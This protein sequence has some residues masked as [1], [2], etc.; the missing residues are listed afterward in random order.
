MTNNK[1]NGH[2]TQEEVSE[3]TKLIKLSIKNQQEINERLEELESKRNA[4]GEAQLRLT[5]LTFDTPDQKILEFTDIPPGAPRKIANEVTLEMLFHPDVQSGKVPLTAIW[6]VTYLR[7][8]RSVRG[9]Q[10][11]RAAGLARDQVQAEG[12]EDNIDRFK[13]GMPE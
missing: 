8:R 10:W 3:L 7:A 13:L 1:D 2:V 9:I 5:N 4:S 12:E 6:R 11:M